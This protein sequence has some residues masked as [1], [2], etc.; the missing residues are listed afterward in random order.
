[1]NLWSA[2]SGVIC[3]VYVGQLIKSVVGILT[4][5]S[6]DEENEEGLFRIITPIIVHQA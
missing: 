3:E 4:N 2:T 1:M 5:T 6:E